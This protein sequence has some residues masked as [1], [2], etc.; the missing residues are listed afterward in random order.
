LFCNWC[1]IYICQNRL[2]NAPS[3]ISCLPAQPVAQDYAS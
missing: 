1:L 3:S 2:A